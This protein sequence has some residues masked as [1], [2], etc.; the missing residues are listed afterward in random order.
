MC[1][2]AV[3]TIY[4]ETHLHGLDDTESSLVGNGGTH[5]RELD[6]NHVAKFSLRVIGDTDS[7]DVTLDLGPLRKEEKI[8]PVQ[9]QMVF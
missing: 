2:Y 4:M 6:V 7:D 1:M 3:S 8:N 5:F 9:C